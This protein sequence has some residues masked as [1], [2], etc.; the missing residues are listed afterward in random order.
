MSA[1]PSAGTTVTSRFSDASKVIRMPDPFGSAE[2]DTDLSKWNEF[3]M[4]FRAWITYAETSFETDLN[5][6]E[7]KGDVVF[8][9]ATLTD[10]QKQ[11]SNQL[12]SIL[13]G[14]LK[15]RPLIVLRGV[16]ERN[17][18]EVWRQLSQIYTPRN[19]S[20]SLAILTTLMQYPPFTKDKTLREQVATLDRLAQEYPRVA[21]KEPSD[22]ILLGTLMRM[23]PSQIRAHLQVQ[24]KEDSTYNDL[25]SKVDRIKGDF[26][27]KGKGKHGWG[28]PSGKKGDVYK[29]KGQDSKG[30]G[31]GYQK[32]KGYGGWSDGKAGK[33]GK[34]GWQSQ[35]YDAKAKGKGKKGASCFSFHVCF[36][37]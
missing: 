28:K 34:G 29:G 4:S 24:L 16:S 11:R 10:T 33:S 30:K 25:R 21:G 32:G 5:A 26:K 22:D 9:F 35:R 3:N 12:Y 19:K 2:S 8:E 23:L 31:K 14:L 36:V 37:A 18:L 20:R 13:T 1:S 27:G 15:H 17:G 7:A 6:A